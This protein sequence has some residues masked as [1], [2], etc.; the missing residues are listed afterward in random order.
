[1]HRAQKEEALALLADHRRALCAQDD[2]CL[3]CLLADGRGTPG[4]VYESEEGIV[5]LDRF[6][7]REGHLIVVSREHVESL[8]ELGWPHYAALQRI[9]FDATRALQRVL[10]PVR[11][12]VAALGAP[13]AVPMSFPHFHLHV[14]PLFEAD[15]SARPARVFSWTDGVVVY[16]D[17]EAEALA[18]R[19]RD[20]WPSEERERHSGARLVRDDL[21]CEGA[22]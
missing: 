11:F 19:I 16:E 21:W 22:E 15:D 12:Y 1:M 7:A 14:I 13:Q 6:A 2:T 4:P 20:A 18:Q 10:S 8:P 3:M 17:D 5:L 9:A